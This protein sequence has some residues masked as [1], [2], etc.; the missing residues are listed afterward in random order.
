MKVAM[1]TVTWAVA[2]GLGAFTAC[3]PQAASV[4]QEK[5]EQAFQIMSARMNNTNEQLGEKL[6]T[7]I[8]LQ[9]DDARL[10][11][12]VSDLWYTAVPKHLQDRTVDDWAGSPPMIAGNHGWTGLARAQ[13]VDVAGKQVAYKSRSITK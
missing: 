8:R 11:L 12:T 10:V 1:V 3:T 5:G 13:F 9:P 4:S 2:A 6:F 7:N